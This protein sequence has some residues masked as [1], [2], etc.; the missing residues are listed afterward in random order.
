MQLMIGK[1]CG[2]CKALEA[3]LKEENITLETVVAEDNM[4]LATE[5]GVKSLP[6]LILDNKTTISG[7]ELIK[8]YLKPEE[9]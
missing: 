7:V 2:A 6:T 9:E 4:D 5:L 1:H 8:E 3:W